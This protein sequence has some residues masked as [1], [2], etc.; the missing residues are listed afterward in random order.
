M[1]K[2][3]RSPTLSRR[4]LLSAAAAS[5]APAR[6]QSLRS[7][8]FSL[9][10][11]SLVAAAP[12]IAHEMGMFGARGLAP[13]FIY[14][15]S[16]NAATSALISG[17]VQIAMSGTADAIAARAR[18]Q[19]V[20][21]IANT[22][23]GLSGSL[24]LAKSVADKLSATSSAPIADRLK[25]LD[26]L[27]IA[28]TS[29]TSSFTFS[30]RASANAVGAKIR[31]T[32]MALPAMLAALESGA[33]QG[34]IA[35]APY[36]AVPVLKGSGIMWIVGPKGELPPEY[37]PASA[38]DLQVMRNFAE[39]EP[40]LVQSVVSVISDFQEAVSNKPADV[41]NAVG[42]LYPELDPAT[43]DLVYATE[44]PAWAAKPLTAQDIAH[45]IAYVKL[46]G[47]DL[48]DLASIEPASMILP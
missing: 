38:A 34:F 33:V 26:G 48:P 27:L 15:D 9:P 37:L 31:F 30:Y 29:A 10:S 42:R 12:R 44:S 2:I 16:A 14:M 25:A 13:K 47:A 19:K 40:A 11:K 28:S 46:G 8:S 43:I 17:S 24:V 6:G 22:F 39:S 23:S 5:I 18:G 45:E 36:W 41:K 4:F 3:I 35:T 21:V 32:F 7:V 1:S 20:V